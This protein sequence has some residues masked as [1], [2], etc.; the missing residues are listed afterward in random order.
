MGWL[1]LALAGRVPKEGERFSLKS[2][3]FTVARLQG[4]RIAQV[5]VTQ[6]KAS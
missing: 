3:E 6:G 4:R 1:V 5:R 2:V